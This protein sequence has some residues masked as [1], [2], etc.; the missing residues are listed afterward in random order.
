MNWRGVGV[1]NVALACILLFSFATTLLGRVVVQFYVIMLLNI[2]IQF[3][4]NKRY[5]SVHCCLAMHRVLALHCVVFPALFSMALRLLGVVFLALHCVVFS[6]LCSAAFVLALALHCILSVHQLCIAWCGIPCVVQRCVGQRCVASHCF[7]SVGQ[8]CVA[9]QRA[10]K[11]FSILISLLGASVILLCIVVQRLCIGS[12]RC[13]ALYSQR[14]LALRCVLALHCIVFSALF[15]VALRLS[16]ALHCILSVVQR[17][18]ASQ[19]HVALYSQCC[20]AWCCILSIAQRCI[21]FYPPRWHG[22]A[23]YSQHWLVWCCTLCVVL[24]S[25]RILSVAAQCCVVSPGPLQPRYTPICR[26]S[27]QQLQ[28]LRSVVQQRQ[29]FQPSRMHHGG[30]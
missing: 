8:R 16:I 21:A 29:H 4:R 19:R 11:L 7:L 5:T 10:I 17:Y 27:C 1:Y 20:V 14:C 9:S 6:A 22:I 13:I 24:A 25:R 2:L 18:I 12:Q 3:T 15:S 30:I 26:V 23:L 28:L